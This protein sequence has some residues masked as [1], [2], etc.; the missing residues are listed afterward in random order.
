M[1]S[2]ER[3]KPSLGLPPEGEGSIA[4]MR[5]V[6]MAQG[7]SSSILSSF[8]ALHVDDRS[9]LSEEMAIT[10]CCSQEY[11]R[12]SSGWGRGGP[13]FL[14]YYSPALMQKVG[15]VD[16]SGALRVLAEVFR[17]ARELWPLDTKHADTTV[18]VRIDALKEMDVARIVEPEIGHFWV[19]SKTSSRDS[20]VTLTPLA[21]L[22]SMNWDE[23]RILSF[24]RRRE[25]KAKTATRF[26]MLFSRSY[27]GLPHGGSG[28]NLGVGRASSNSSRS[29]NAP[30]G[31]LVGLSRS[32]RGAQA[33]GADKS[34]KSK[35]RPDK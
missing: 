5:L 32:M 1:E 21:D 4:K 16:P 35:E 23:N 33:P 17:Q 14:L 19:L 26:N 27:R 2:W 24:S 11:C 20:V 10:G 34:G 22:Q 15:A 7:D 12:D 13:A 29:G 25:T 31:L 3:H 28:S 30:K 9:L 8:Q 6:L 18:I